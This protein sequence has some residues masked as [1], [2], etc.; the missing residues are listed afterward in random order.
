MISAEAF[1]IIVF[2]W[3]AVGVAT[4]VALQWIT[5]PYGRHT[6]AFG[7]MISNR[8][9]W[10]IMEIPGVL[11]FSLLFFSGPF[12]KTP[13][14]YL[15]W[16]LYLIHY[17]NRSL[18]YPWRTKTR[19][20]KMPV[21]IMGSAVFFNLCNGAILGYGF[22]WMELVYPD[23]YFQSPL[24]L[25]GAFLFLAGA[26]INLSSDNTLLSLRKG[27]ETGY[28]I[29]YGGMFRLISCPNHFGEIV[30]WIGFAVMAAN[31][32]AMS[33][34]LWTAAN[35]IPRARDH[36][37]WYQSHFDNYPSDRKAVLPYLF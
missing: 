5:A 31:P 24:F 17:I 10:M 11:I 27:K 20:K 37:K 3:M 6:R 19:G 36:H 14:H 25:I 34:A 8:L 22:G 7:P 1:Q 15:F 4:F 2:V 26:C 9:A 21:A 28:K 12:P 30:E 32:A 33:F 16:S 29:P 18:I 23:D 35:L 13:Y